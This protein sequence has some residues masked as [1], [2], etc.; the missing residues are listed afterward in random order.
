[1]HRAQKNFRIFQNRVTTN[2]IPLAINTKKR[3]VINCI[4][5]ASKEEKG[6]MKTNSVCIPNKASLTK[7]VSFVVNNALF[8][9]SFTSSS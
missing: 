6:G 1:M 3:I 9:I 2:H 8:G 7:K 5:K 4:H